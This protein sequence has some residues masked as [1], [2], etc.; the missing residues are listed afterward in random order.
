LL[1]A[2]NLSCVMLLC[3]INRATAASLLL[4]LGTEESEVIASSLVVK[5]LR[6]VTKGLVPGKDKEDD[7]TAILE[8]FG[9]W[10]KLAQPR[11]SQL[12]SAPGGA[13]SD[14]DLAF[15]SL[16]E[17]V[18]EVV[19]VLQV[20]SPSA[21]SAWADGLR[22]EERAL[23]HSCKQPVGSVGTEINKENVPTVEIV[24]SKDVSA[25]TTDANGAEAPPFV[26]VAR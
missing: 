24:S 23:L 8:A 12:P 3:N 16:L 26:T 15:V 19:D 22:A 7:I 25:K 14:F 6:K 4:E 2:I 20:A 13:K 5:C 11:L 21:A 10:L 1:R 17:G 18:R 9:R